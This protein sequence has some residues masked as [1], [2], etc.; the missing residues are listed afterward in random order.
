[1]ANAVLVGV[2]PVYGLYAAMM[3]PG[4]GGLVSS[5]NL[6][7][8]T[9]TAAASLTTS[10]ALGGLAGD[11]RASALFVMVILIGVF[12]IVFGLS[13]AG[14]TDPLRVLL[15]HDRVPQRRVPAA[16]P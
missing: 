13:G 7:L 4:V 1:M 2:N 14:E 9:T 12:Q 16:D 6:M 8:I 3:G 5:T 15:G 10:Q 11:A